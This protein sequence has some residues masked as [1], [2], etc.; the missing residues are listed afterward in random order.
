MGAFVS[1][2]VF[3]WTAGPGSYSGGGTRETAFP[4]NGK[5]AGTR[6]KRLSEVDRALI[7]IEVLNATS[8]PGL[9]DRVTRLLRSHGFDVVDYGN[10]P[11]GPADSSAILD[12][13]GNPAFVRE[14]ALALPG[15]PIRQGP[16]PDRFVDVTIVVG[17]DYARLLAS[18]D[19][20]H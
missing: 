8:V 14:V 6:E 1:S 3:R 7:R 2:L 10:A 15:T 11:D 19:A 5:S 4:E 9:A 16:S 17:G 12:R 20:R 13:V 18:L